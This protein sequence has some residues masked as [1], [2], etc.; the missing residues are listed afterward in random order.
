MQF[1][2]PHIHLFDRDRGDYGWLKPSSPPH[3]PDKPIINH[4]FNV[5]DLHVHKGLSLAGF[6]HVEAGFNNEQPWR[7]IEWLESVVEIPFKAI[8]CVDLTAAPQVFQ[9]VIN[10]L[11][12]YVSVVGVRYLFDDEAVSILSHVNTL[13]NLEYLRDSRLLFETQISAVDSEAVTAF[14]H[15]ARALPQ[16]SIVLSHTCFSPNDPHGYAL[17]CQQ[18]HRLASCG[19]I[20]I[21]ASGWE[22]V[23][24]TYELA[25]VFRVTTTLIAAFGDQ[26][27]MLASNFPLTLF[28]RSYQQLWLDYE[29]LALNPQTKKRLAFGN[30][31]RLYDFDF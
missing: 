30:A 22:M 21:K 28:S 14:T 17:W 2:D 16:L 13:T 24:R 31:N 6:V 26:R 27:V 11:C 5:S 23:S 3:W 12:S 19:N 25:D 9:G 8:A 10:K 20:H 18:V 1:I 4:D 7:E 29:S 15:M